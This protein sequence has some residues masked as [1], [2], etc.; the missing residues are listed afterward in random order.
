MSLKDKL[1]PAVNGTASE[2]ERRQRLL[3]ELLDAFER[4]GEDAVCRLLRTKMDA[5]EQRFSERLAA[6]QE[7]LA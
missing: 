3:A 2:Q 4:D 1:L 6:L 5:L 7:K